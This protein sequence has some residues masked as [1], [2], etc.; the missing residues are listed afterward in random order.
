MYHKTKFSCKRISSSDNTFKKSY[1]DYIILNKDFDFE[2]SKP[3]ILKDNLAHTDASPYQVVLCLCVC[4][5]VGVK[6]NSA[7]PAITCM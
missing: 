7:S 2:D 5:C 6:N 4:M 3:I 1:F